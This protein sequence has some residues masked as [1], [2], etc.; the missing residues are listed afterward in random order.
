MSI[1]A[2]DGSSNETVGSNVVT[3]GGQRYV[4]ANEQA[5]AAGGGI[6]SRIILDGKL[7]L[8]DDGK[9]DPATVFRETTNGSLAASAKNIKAPV[10]ASEGAK[11]A[12]SSEQQSRSQA[13]DEQ[14]RR[15]AR[16]TSLQIAVERQRVSRLRAELYKDQQVIDVEA[17]NIEKARLE[18]MSA[19]RAMAALKAANELDVENARTEQSVSIVQVLPTETTDTDHSL[20]PTLSAA[21]P[22]TETAHH[23]PLAPI[24]GGQ[25][26]RYLE[27]L[28]VNYDVG[29]NGVLLE[30]SGSGGSR[31]NF[32]GKLGVTDEYQEILVGG[33]Y[34]LKPARVDRL[35]LALLA[36]IEYGSFELVDK[37]SPS[38]AIDFSDS[39]FYLAAM[40]RLMLTRRF[41]INAGVGYSSFFEGDALLFGGANYQIG[42]KLDLLTR[43]ELGD[44]DLLGIGLR[45]YY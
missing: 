21:S 41:E 44:N 26:F 31:V 32:F 39:G 6:S 37:Q 10:I 40:S 12:A 4:R 1:S 42:R 18:Q 7:Y 3:I 11:K 2:A 13:F 34:Y 24:E 22:L 33:G 16:A 15:D 9:L 38:V 43:F 30:A 29:G 20:I 23:K 35:T 28:L 19:S 5:S 8:L 27:V 45:Y 36:G 17:L 14:R 25:K